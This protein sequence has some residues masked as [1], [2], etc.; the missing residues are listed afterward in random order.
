MQQ[1]TLKNDAQT[2]SQTTTHVEIADVNVIKS[3]N[4]TWSLQTDPQ[5]S[6]GAVSQTAQRPIIAA[7]T[8]EYLNGAQIS[9][10]DHINANN[11]GQPE[12]M[13]MEINGSGVIA[14][15]TLDPSL[16]N[17]PVKYDEQ[18]ARDPHP[19]HLNQPHERLPS[20]GKKHK[21]HTSGNK[22]S[23]NKLIC[24]TTTQTHTYLKGTTS[25]NMKKDQLEDHLPLE[26][27]LK[28]NGKRSKAMECNPKTIT[29]KTVEATR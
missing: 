27:K 8:T 5:E 1:T 22:L 7:V 24:H 14:S 9:E 12:I 28:Q 2:R 16:I 11:Y 19:T 25:R 13:G 10:T 23:G 15:N 6:H 29:I 4:D 20:M 3:I 18:K 21:P 17:V 26:E